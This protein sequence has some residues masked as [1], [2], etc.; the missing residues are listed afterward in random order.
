[1]NE[2]WAPLL[3]RVG[4][5]ASKAAATETTNGSTIALSFAEAVNGTTVWTGDTAGDQ[6]Q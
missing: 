4:Q 5:H 3:R 2:N 6:M 1:L